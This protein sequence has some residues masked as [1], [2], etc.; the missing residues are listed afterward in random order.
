MALV[1]AA[2]LVT[3][4]TRIAGL[5]I[6]SRSEDRKTGIR[7]KSGTASPRGRAC[8]AL[9]GLLR[10]VPVAAFAA[11]IAPNLGRGTL[12]M[13]SCRLRAAVAGIVVLRVRH[14]WA[15]IGAGMAACWAV[16]ALAA[17]FQGR[18]FEEAYSPNVRDD[19][20]PEATPGPTLSCEQRSP[21]VGG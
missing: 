17:A 18:R 1:L 13:L 7:A 2:A 14:L 20:L 21:S 4:A 3:Y 10:Y 9:D 8:T 19:L 12:E 5:L 16:A 11:L 6:A 15:G